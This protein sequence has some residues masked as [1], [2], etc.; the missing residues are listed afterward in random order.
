MKKKEK[1]L[2]F[3]IPALA[4][5]P[6][7]ILI[8]ILNILQGAKYLGVLDLILS[9]VLA[10]CLYGLK[11]LAWGRAV[12]RTA[13]FS[14]S[15]VFLYG[16]YLGGDNGSLI[17]WVF[18]LPLLTHF[19]MGKNEGLLLSILAYL[20]TA[21]IMFLPVKLTGAHAY[22]FSVEVKFLVALLFVTIL[23][24]RYEAA[25]EETQEGLNRERRK[26]KQANTT[27]QY[28]KTAIEQSIDGI[29]LA[30]EDRCIQFANQAWAS[31]HGYEQEELE[32]KPATIFHSPE[33]YENEVLPFLDKVRE[34]GSNDGEMGHVR[35]D[36]TEFSCWMSISLVLDDEGEP[37]GVVAVAKDI[38]ERK[39]TE[40]ALLASEERNRALLEA[41]PDAVTVYDKN[42]HVTYVNPAFEEQ[43]GWTAGEVLGK[44]LNFVLP[45]DRPRTDELI[46]QMRL[47]K[48][49][50]EET[51]RMTKDGRI[52]DIQASASMFWDKDHHFLGTVVITR[53]ITE[54]KKAEMALKRA[55]IEAEAANLA[56][57]QFVANI[58]HEIRTPMNGVIGMTGLLLD[59][60]LDERQREFAETI[61]SSGAN[62]L[63]VINDVLDFSKMEADKLELESLN[64]D[65]R[66]TLEDTSD[67]L[68]IKAQEKGLEFICM[69][70][71]EVP[72]LLIG[73]P[74][75]LRQILINICN[76]AI[77]FTKEGEVVVQ[78]HLE[79]E[80]NN[81]TVLRFSISD[82]GIGIPQD[83]QEELFAPFTQMDTST[84]REY[85]GTG[86]G[87]S[88]CKRLVDLMHGEIGVTSQPGKGS[89][90]WFSMPFRR[91][92][93]ALEPLPTGTI[94]G[95][96]ILIVDDNATNRRLVTVLLDTWG[97]RFDEAPDAPEALKK[98]KKSTL[99][100]ND[101]YA[102]VI[103]DMQMPVMD[104]ETLGM[105]VKKDPA[106]AH[107]PLVMMTSIANR[108]DAARLSQIGFSAYLTKPIKQSV[109]FDCLQT[110]LGD[111]K[112]AQATQAKPILT[113]PCH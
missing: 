35:R 109:L 97:C 3:V 2:F 103:T 63:T 52:L 66:F 36:G 44:P 60:D 18:L 94:Q 48:S 104:G 73:D 29:A 98:M 61:R 65:L 38:S 47:G 19:L 8:G 20:C 70:D 82:T 37:T 108:G 59:T 42:G 28:L 25:R 6:A 112:P 84:T 100:E 40:A 71:P 86:L 75:R 90:F 11:T 45:E 85:G 51:R 55:K 24:N 106:L 102:V 43:F 91:Q 111:K 78:V 74:G 87:L 68:A 34:R 95:Q 31:M 83:R 39:I 58:S 93:Q 101:P 33:Q 9:G 105:L 57:S 27:L 32:G 16:I 64:F 67:L 96:R 77:K 107:I 89:T 46:A 15:I 50:L 4:G 69:V 54:R 53:D 1:R 23:A 10:S 12:Y 7:S 62:L 80:K 81:E 17:F 72:S 79:G 110:V 92:S 56:K 88:I 26:L 21:A 49:V 113:R 14:A 41:T 5:I 99:T 22:P 13:I 76:N 30:G